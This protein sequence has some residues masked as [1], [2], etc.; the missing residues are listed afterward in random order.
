VALLDS[1]YAQNPRDESVVRLYVR[2]SIQ[3]AQVRQ[4]LGEHRPALQTLANAEPLLARLRQEYPHEQGLHVDHCGLGMARAT[5][6]VAL[7]EFDAAQQRWSDLIAEFA[8]IEVDKA[9]LRLLIALTSCHNNLSR[10]AHARGDHEQAFALLERGL[11]LDERVLAQDQSL[12]VVL[13]SVR[14]RLNLAALHRQ[15]GRLDQTAAIY[16]QVL[17]SL[18]AQPA[19]QARDP[20]LR[21]ELART[22]FAVAELAS[23]RSQHAAAAPWREAG[24]QGFRELV[25]EFPERTAYRQDLGSMQYQ[26]ANSL[27]AAGDTKAGLASLQ[28][29]IDSHRQLLA[30]LPEAPEPCSELATFVHRLSELQ[31]QRGE[32][33]LA[34]TTLAEAIAIQRRALSLRPGDAHY[35]WELAYL[36]QIEGMMQAKLDRWSTARDRWRDAAAGYEQAL[37]AGYQRAREPKSLTRTLQMLA[38]AEHVC[39]EPDAVVQTLERLQRVQPMPPAELEE[40]GNSL[41]VG[42]HPGFVALRAAGAAAADGAQAQTGNPSAGQPSGR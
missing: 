42:K 38:Q 3:A 25:Q 19:A 23:A 32:Q 2:G 9:D 35:T 41:G 12:P 40:V 28:A 5:S 4:Q 33:Q 8:D 16:D 34:T 39:D 11:R 13:D 7:G 29:A 30:R 18:E 1:L 10:M 17:A 26:A 37:A 21:R 36:Q 15:A 14:M 6:L 27:L 31:W 24:M 22:R 20:E